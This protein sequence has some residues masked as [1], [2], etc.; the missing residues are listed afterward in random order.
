[1]FHHKLLPSK[2]TPFFPPV[3]QSK[4]TSRVVTLVSVSQHDSAC[5]RITTAQSCRD[6]PGAT[7]PPTWVNGISLKTF[8]ASALAVARTAR[9]QWSDLRARGYLR[10]WRGKGEE[11]WR[12]RGFNLLYLCVSL[13]REWQKK[14]KTSVTHMKSN[15]NHLCLLFFILYHLYFPSLSVLCPPPWLDATQRAHFSWD[16]FSFELLFLRCASFPSFFISLCP[17]ML[18]FDSQRSTFNGSYLL[19]KYLQV[20]AARWQGWR[21]RKRERQSSDWCCSGPLQHDI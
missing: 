6:F 5:R 7:G 12:E 21:E 2:T 13:G 4:Q 18:S 1:M 15:P 17:L 16:G 14:V 11:W 10:C 19:I 20:S 8:R 9:W 3:S